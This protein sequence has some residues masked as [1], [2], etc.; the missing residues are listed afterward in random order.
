MYDK[1]VIK[2]L[3][4]IHEKCIVW[5]KAN[6]EKGHQ[7]VSIARREAEIKK[8]TEKKGVN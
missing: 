4:K 8:L 6:N 5:L 3:I 2:K 1:K 7:N